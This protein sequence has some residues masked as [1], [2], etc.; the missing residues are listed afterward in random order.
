[1]ININKNIKIILGDICYPKSEALILPSNSKG[2][3]NKGILKKIKQD[4]W[5]TIEKEAKECIINEKL[6]IG[7]VF[8]TGPGKLRRRGVKNIYHC[9]IQ[10]VPGQTIS[11][12]IL[13]KILYKS[14]LMVKNDGYSSVTVSNLSKDSGTLQKISEAR[15]ILAECQKILLNIRIIDD[16]LEFIDNLNSLD[17][18]VKK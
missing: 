16:D 11:S 6:G 1:M 17:K 3:M 12:S 10:E 14:L 5:K 7:D 18:Q 13:G 4:G 15:I 8:V 9:I 2:V